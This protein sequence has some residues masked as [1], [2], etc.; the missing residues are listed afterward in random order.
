MNID[1]IIK[2]IKDDSILLRDIN[3]EGSV[4]CNVCKGGIDGMIW[5]ICTVCID[6]DICTDLLDDT[7]HWHH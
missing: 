1:L 3:P 4:E 6:F 7:T 2:Q 5:Y